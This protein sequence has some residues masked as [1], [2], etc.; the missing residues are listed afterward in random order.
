KPPQ[1]WDEWLA[2]CKKIKA[3]GMTPLS[4]AGDGTIDAFF[5]TELATA[6]L[7]R[8]G[9][10]DL[11]AGKMKFTSPAIVATMEFILKLVPYFQPGFLATKYVDSKALFATNKVVMF[12]AGSADQAGFLQINP[13]IDSGVFAFP[14]PKRGGEH[15][16]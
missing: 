5:F 8:T 13:R 15:V 9:Y 4:M 7:G 6:A 14:P 11:A 10:N 1:D 2:Q 12:E 3:A 16:T